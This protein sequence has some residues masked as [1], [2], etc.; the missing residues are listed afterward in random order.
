MIIQNIGSTGLAATPDTG[1]AKVAS[2]APTPTPAPAPEKS[3][4]SQQLHAAVDT[5]NHAMAQSNQ[6]LQFSVDTETKRPV[7]TVVDSQTG[8]VIMQFPSKAILA[9]AHSIDQ[10][11]SGMLLNHKA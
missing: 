9:I 5:M 6:S 8:D 7:V 11:Q 2:P 1:A 4:T 3:A 10:Y